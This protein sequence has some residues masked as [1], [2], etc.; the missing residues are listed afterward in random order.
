VTVVIDASVVL[1]WLLAD[2]NTESDTDRAVAL[3]HAIVDGELDIVQPAHWLCEV[4]AVLA[5]AAPTTAAGDLERLYAMEFPIRH[6]AGVLRRA[7]ELSIK[8][9]PHLFDT[10]YYA[11]ARETDD[12]TL[13]TADRRY[14]R[15]ARSRGRICA[16]T[17]WKHAS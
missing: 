17:E 9:E 6:E 12:A 10:L 8:L 2:P 13:V 11:V 14:L 7:C 4:G 3:M 15:A 5:H 1:R 16:L